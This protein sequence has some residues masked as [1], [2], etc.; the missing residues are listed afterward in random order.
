M[1]RPTP[2][3]IRE[4]IVK[5]IKYTPQSQSDWGWA[6]PIYYELIKGDSTHCEAIEW[7][8]AEFNLEPKENFETMANSL[9]GKL[10]REKNK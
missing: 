9:A 5:A 3:E 8:I 7:I 10:H 6:W 4:A 1:Y 2:L